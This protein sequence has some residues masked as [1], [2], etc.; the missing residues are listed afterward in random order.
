VPTLTQGDY[1]PGVEGDAAAGINYRGWDWGRANIAPIAQVIG[2]VRGRDN[3]NDADPDNSG[4]QRILL[5]PGIE[6]HLHPVKIYADV[7]IP[8]YQNMKGDQ[9]VAPALFKVSLSYMF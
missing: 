1:R 4:Y 9:L 7:E 3:G 6:V 8:V 5:S 2:S